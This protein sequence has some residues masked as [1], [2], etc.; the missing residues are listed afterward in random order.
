MEKLTMTVREV[1]TEMRKAGI[2]CTDKSVSDGIAMGAYPFGRISHVGPSGR[3]TL[4]IFRVDFYAWLAS[5]AEPV[6]K[7]TYAPPIRF[8]RSV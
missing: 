8:L 1:L 5:K 6:K 3:R 4:E 7:D 2:P